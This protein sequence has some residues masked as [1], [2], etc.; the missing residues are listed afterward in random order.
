LRGVVFAG[1]DTSLQRS[2]IYAASGS[3]IQVIADEQTST[4]GGGLFDDLQ[5]P[6]C[7]GEVVGFVGKDLATGRYGIYL[8]VGAQPLTLVVQEGMAA[9][10]GGGSLGGFKRPDLSG[11]E[12]A[13]G[14]SVVPAGIE[15]I[16]F[17]RAAPFVLEA[18]AD[19]QT[20]VPGSPLVFSA[21]GEP[22][23]S[24]E[25]L[26]F[27]GLFGLGGS[28]VYS[29]FDGVLEPVADENTPVPGHP[30]LLFSDFGEPSVWSDQ[31]AFSA[32]Y[33]GGGGIY[34]ATTSGLEEVVALGELAPGGGV[35]VGLDQAQ[36]GP[37]ALAFL[38]VTSKGDQALFLELDGNLHRVVG[39]GDVLDGEQLFGITYKL[40]GRGGGEG[41]LRFHPVRVVTRGEPS[42]GGQ[43]I[44][45]HLLG[46]LRVRVPGGF[47]AED[48]RRVLSVL[49]EAG[50]C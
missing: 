48:L 35:F 12:I 46:G 7:A 25:R 6:A 21:F 20:Q 47:A 18:A 43:P 5:L 31:I 32:L 49:S 28:G 39:F 23:L 9:P 30:G 29:W 2:G 8:S 11:E 26:A 33:S 19:T 34:R 27:R 45:I 50:P 41:S 42:G 1:L 10:Q 38:G 14:A 24:E 40:G 4:P 17:V 37:G 22:S 13:F 36:L 15:G 16:F 3:G 44:E